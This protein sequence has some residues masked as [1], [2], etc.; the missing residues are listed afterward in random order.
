MDVRFSWIRLVPATL[1]IA[2]LS[3]SIGATAAVAASGKGDDGW[4][5]FPVDPRSN[6]A[7]NLEA[8]RHEGAMPPRLF[9]DLRSINDLAVNN[10]AADSTARD[11]QSE[12]TVAVTG[13]ASDK[14][15]AG[16]NDS[17]SWDGVTGG[18]ND[19]F[20]GFAS[21]TNSGATFTDQGALPNTAQGDGGDPVLAPVA[22][23]DTVYLAT[24]QF[25]SNLDIPI[26]KSTD[27]GA[28]FA[29]P[30]SGAPG[31]V[32]G[33]S[34]DKPWLVV[35]NFGGSGNGNVYLCWTRFFGTNSA[36]IR[37]TRSINSG[38]SFGPSGGTLISSG[39]QGCFVVVG[40]DHSVYVFYYRGTGPG[41]QGGD[42]K[43]FVRRSTDL[44][45]TFAPEVQVA[46]LQTTTTNGRLELGAGPRSNSFPHAA[47]NPVSGQL[48]AV[49]N[50]DTVAGGVDNGNAFYVTSTDNGATWSPPKEVSD[51]GA[52]DQ[53]FPTVGITPNGKRI[54]FGYYSRTHDP[55]GSFHR[56]ARAGTVNTNTDAIKLRR[57]F[58]LGYDTP[59]AIAQDPAINPTYMGDYD[60]IVANSGRFFS[61]WA[62]NRDGNGFHTSQ[63][64][65]FIARID[66]NA[67]KTTTDLGVALTPAVGSINE[68]GTTSLTLDTTAIGTPA[69][70]VFVSVE[71]EPGLT[72]QS[73]G[74]GSG[75]RVIRNVV[76]CSLGTIAA[77]TTV[78]R[79]VNVLGAEGGTK[80]VDAFATSSDKDTSNGNNKDGANLNV[81][82]PP[83]VGEFSTGTIGTSIPDGPAGSVNIPI[84]VGPAGTVTDVDAFVR[85]SHTFDSDLDLS[86]I[87]PDGS[88]T[89]DLSSDNGGGF[90]NYGSGAGNCGGTFT[91]FDDGA[92]TAITAAA[93]PFAGTFRPEAALSGL[94]G[95]SQAGT[96]T[97]RVADDT[98]V[99]I[100]MVHCAK[101]RIAN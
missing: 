18:A 21:S 80:Q 13:P 82:F 12:T 25:T 30:V 68:G 35:D 74:G 23:T 88:P 85:I 62:D 61:T 66:K 63:P 71:R 79:T 34:M 83:N 77:G 57:S 46:D 41:G 67:P 91:R 78:S 54:M 27:G 70:D 24:L 37:F 6:G 17:G 42:N 38:A 56:R 93:A 97:L 2:A 89:I 11:T 31:G 55:G 15:V 50:D 84:V 59:V 90:D 51:D 72:Y 36:D 87:P 49:Y 98:A 94:N 14:V 16:F 73:V 65:V 1:A 22:G 95:E 64:D 99:D 7:L 29:A 9:P 48:V 39:G 92:A 75:C 8:A 58:Q 45:V 3:L 69:H 44:G 60:Q 52:A 33:D 86:L 81:N 100:G 32:A 101:L 20:T 53:F 26:F 19:H 40:P 4:R 76:G 96:W 47:V 43:L 5:G 28:S 10:P